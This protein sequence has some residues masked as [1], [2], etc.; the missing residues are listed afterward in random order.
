MVKKIEFIS[1]F[2]I[3]SILQISSVFGQISPSPI[4]SLQ[5]GQWYEVPNS[6]IRSVVP[7]PIPPG[8]GPAGIIRAW[9]GGAYDTKRDRLIVWGG[10]HGDYGG[11]ELYTFDINT[12][13]WTRIW[14]PTNVSL[15]PPASPPSACSETYSDGNPRSRHTYGGLQYLPNIDRFWNSGGSLYCGS[16]GASSGTW[17]FNFDTLTW[18]RKADFIGYAELEHVSAYDPVTGRVFF[19]NTA[20]PLHQY[21]PITDTWTKLT[22]MPIGNYKSG[23]IDPKRRKFVIVGAGAVYAYDLPPKTD[24]SRKTLITTGA[25]EIING[26]R[27]GIVYDPVT[28]R[29]VAWNGGADLYSLN[30][31]TLV[32]TKI[33]PA[34]SNTVIPTAATA[35]G[36]YGRFQYIP[37]KNA[38]IVVNSI[39]ENVFIYR[40]SSNASSTTTGQIDIP[41]KTWIALDAPWPF[42]NKGIPPTNKHVSPAYH[43]P[44]GR[45]YFNG[46]DYAGGGSYDNSYRQETWSLSIAERFANKTDRT[47]G[48]RLEYPY[49]GPT[50]QI[51]PKHPDYTGFVWDSKREVFYMV[52]G[53]MESTTGTNCPGETTDKVTNP[54]FISG[55]MMSFNPVTKTWQIVGDAGPDFQDTWMTPYDPVSDTIIRFGLSLKVNV[56][57]VKTG[58]WTAFG[59]VPNH[60]WKEYLAID[61]PGRAIYGVAGFNGKLYKYSIDAKTFEDL[62]SVPEGGVGLDNQAHV[63]WDSL[64]KILYYYRLGIS[65]LYVYHPDTK[66][67]ET[68]P[69]L[70]DIPGVSARGRL[71][72]Y[73]PGQNVLLLM[74]GVDTDTD[75]YIF[76]YRYAKSE[77]SAVDNTPPSQVTGLIAAPVSSSQ[78]DLN[79]NLA[80]DNV[81]VAGYRIY[82]NNVQIATSS[83]N[84]YNDFGLTAST[85]Y[86]YKI[87]AYDAAGNIGI[88]STQAGAT[89]LASDTTAPII[90]NIAIPSITSTSAVVT[91][92]TNEMSTHQVE[93]GLTDSYG[94]QTAENTVLMASHSQ[95]LAS[96]LPNTLYHFRVK[97]KDAS[98][99]LAPSS[100]NTFKTLPASSALIINGTENTIVLQDGLNGYSGTKDTYIYSWN[101]VGNYG[102]SIELQSSSVEKF[103]V[104]VGFEIYQSESGPV[105][106]NAT[107]KSATL[108]LYKFTNYDFS[109]NAK[110]LLKAWKENEATWNNANS[111][112]KWSTPGADG[113]SD[114]LVSENSNGRIGWNPD[115]INFDVTKNVQDFSSTANNGWN[116]IS[117]SDQNTRKFFSKEYSDPA[118][119]PKLTIIY[120]EPQTTNISI[121]SDVNNDGGVDLLDLLIV[122]KDLGK[123]TGFDPKVDIA[124]PFGA[125]DIFDVVRVVMDLG[126]ISK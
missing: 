46:G 56:Y 52:P 108:S 45:I 73:D 116:I 98:G 59:G 88:P 38:F 122:A 35:T 40:L 63:A 119:R 89:T 118:L 87:A 84:F 61:V 58:T 49:C 70:T 91:W 21:D 82:R 54:G 85:A 97:S 64:N 9:S 94:S 92:N 37:S 29:I 11:N 48:W 67:W 71:M 32:W 121:K 78:I 114:I 39:D 111:L 4:D 28:D 102:S 96:L 75:K 47:A 3:V 115:W 22:D 17:T 1:V 105:P 19:V 112:T 60:L 31:D 103:N 8:D 27:I 24:F 77:S 113:T 51:Q 2:F 36:T 123:T 43:P 5:P 110:R 81:G 79:W 55:K 6:K 30:L 68:L 95:S 25:N 34:P 53:V 93:Y 14:G 120:V 23:T 104:L 101:S 26:A 86:N 15:I 12:L 69:L 66:T 20:A 13:K 106:N 10:G 107:I 124:A 44:S 50:G 76:L 125:I 65:N 109:A 74:G 33:P 57:D 62:G 100:D 117:L 7:S 99:N 80:T 41:S 42:S 72:V 18:E 83:M 126:K 90:N 16:G